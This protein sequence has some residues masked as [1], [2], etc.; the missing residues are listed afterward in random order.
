M[1]YIVLFL[2]LIGGNSAI[3]IE[4]SENHLG[5]ADELIGISEM[6][7][8]DVSA[9]AVEVLD[10][11]QISTDVENYQDIKETYI[12]SFK[13]DYLMQVRELYVSYY[14]EEDI[15]ALIQFYKSE[16]GKKVLKNTD[17]LSNDI[18]LSAELWTEKIYSKLESMVDEESK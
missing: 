4:Y 8:V 10:Y 7:G 5:L 15:K 3:S 17:Q 11:F 14:S 2:F 1:K 12:E 16:I 9:I 13:N 6:N 18:V